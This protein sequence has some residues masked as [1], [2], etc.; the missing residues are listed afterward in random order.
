MQFLFYHEYS[1]YCNNRSLLLNTPLLTLLLLAHC[2]RPRRRQP[3][4]SLDMPQ[5][6]VA[7]LR[8]P[9]PAPADTDPSTSGI[10]PGRAAADSTADGT[11]AR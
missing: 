1:S 2:N 10:R 8:R 9:P 3:P 5:P 4:T 11:P 7:G 6:A